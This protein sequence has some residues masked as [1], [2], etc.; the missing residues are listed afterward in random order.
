MPG[1]RMKIEFTPDPT[2]MKWLILALLIIAGA[3]M[4]E[5]MIMVGL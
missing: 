3:N 2:M 5:L 1:L 4:D